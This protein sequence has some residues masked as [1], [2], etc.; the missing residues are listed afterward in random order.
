MVSYKSIWLV[1]VL[2]LKKN[3]NNIPVLYWACMFQ[4][5][6]PFCVFVTVYKFNKSTNSVGVDKQLKAELHA[7]SVFFFEW[8]MM[9]PSE[10]K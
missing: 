9:S 5:L 10:N 4:S 6:I 1:I 2:E 7:L 8:R 3:N